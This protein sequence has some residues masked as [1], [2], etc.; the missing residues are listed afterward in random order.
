MVSLEVNK[1]KSRLV[2]CSWAVNSTPRAVFGSP[3]LIGSY[4]LSDLFIY[5]FSI[6]G[7]GLR[8]ESE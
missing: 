8:E 5:L 4:W 1:E 2:C 7:M 3:W 6:I